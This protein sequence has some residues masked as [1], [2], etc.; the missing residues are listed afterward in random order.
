M[1]DLLPDLLLAPAV[2]WVA[3][4]ALTGRDLFRSVVFFIAFGL[5]LSI[6][7]VRLA[8]PDVALAEAAI[9]TGLTGALLLDAVGQ[10][11]RG[12]RE[13]GRERRGVAWPTA[14]AVLLLAAGLV[15]AYAPLRETSGGLAREVAA[16]LEPSGVSNP[17]TA[18]LLN[19]RA[20]D[21][22]LE[23]AVLLLGVL[24]LL[25]LHGRRDLSRVPAA[26]R[27]DP[28]LSWLVRLVLP[29][30]LVAGAHLLLVGS[31]APGGAFQSAV[32]M[33]G[34]AILLLLAGG[35][36][37]TAV[38]GRLLAAALL[39][40]LS[41]FLV[42]AAVPLFT[43]ER[44]LQLRGETAGRVILA[45]EAALAISLAVALAALFA[46]ARPRAGSAG[47]DR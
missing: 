32:V 42:A 35:R 25:V 27:A 9:G 13:R 17:V 23:V 37:I 33:G 6:V 28:V 14:L 20:Y 10:T 24:G 4:H 3:W 45:V 2:V 31:H 30:M 11:E 15:M 5:L 12:A 46:G 1:P 34:G 36:S 39:L 21:T 41:A 47:E 19:F 16:H 44:F 22:L 26:E 43:G 7:W 38:R 8:A 40:G 18:V 29:V